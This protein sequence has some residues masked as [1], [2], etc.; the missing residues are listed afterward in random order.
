MDT[1]P[2]IL[3]HPTNHNIM[4]MTSE[5]LRPK[6]SV[7]HGRNGRLDKPELAHDAGRAAALNALQA[8]PAN[9]LAVRLSSASLFALLKLALGRGEAMAAKFV[10]GSQGG[11]VTREDMAALVEHGYAE[12]RKGGYSITD[13]GNALVRELV[14]FATEWKGGDA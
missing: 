4:S 7:S 8:V 6:M 11:G 10:V 14:T 1:R 12:P 5:G 3:S 2:G 9:T 13:R